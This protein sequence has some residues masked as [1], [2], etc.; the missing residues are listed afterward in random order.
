MIRS[1]EASL[2]RL[3][4]DGAVAADATVSDLLLQDSPLRHGEG[5]DL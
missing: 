2:K 4:T 5:P 1:L 3:G